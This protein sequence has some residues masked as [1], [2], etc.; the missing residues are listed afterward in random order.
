MNF[1]Q[2]LSIPF[3]IGF[4]GAGVEVKADDFSATS[5]VT[6]EANF[7]VGRTELEDGAVADDEEL[8]ALYSYKV[9]SITSFSGNDALKV[10]VEAG[11]APLTSRLRSESTV[12]GSDSIKAS[13][14]YYSTSISDN[15]LIA[16]GPV[17]DMDALVS[18][19]T[20]SYSND[21]IFNGYFLGPNS[22]SNHAKVGVPGISL[23]YQNDNG[24]NAG[25]SS[26]WINGADS[27][28]GIGGEGFDMTRL[29][30][31]YDNDDFGGGI[32]YTMYDDPTELFDT[33][34]DEAGNEIT[35]SILG[36]PVFLGVGAY[37]NLNDKFD[38]SVGVDFLDF[39]YKNFDV[40]TIT[41]VAADYDLGPGTISGAFSNI[42]GYDFSNGQKDDAGVAYEFYY[43]WD[44]ADDITVKPMIMMLELDRSGNTLWADE[45]I[46][47]LETTF[48]F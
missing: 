48:K 22:L 11:N 21:G 37:W 30:L 3:A 19:T 10:S 40:A 14:I 36:D 31:G 9:D 45:T 8:H 27:T 1:R 23:A 35:G 15:L 24:L 34:Y 38:I 39:D 6:G 47:G 33:V 28:K 5:V 42:P 43:N 7:T 16:G 12:Y 44:V 17:Y 46:V 13:N 25:V 32:I 26:L 18:T 41:S 4:L 29:S 20:S 2:I